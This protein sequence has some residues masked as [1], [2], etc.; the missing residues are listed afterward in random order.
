MTEHHR[1]ML[2]ELLDHLEFLESRIEEFSRRIEEVS[3]P[4]AP[5]IAKVATLPGFDQRSAQ[6]VVAEIGADMNVFPSA[7]HL[8]S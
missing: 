2:R 8:A 1:F 3:R 6:N 4:F 5:A 7:Q